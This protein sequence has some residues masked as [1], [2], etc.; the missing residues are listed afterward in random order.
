MR[1]DRKSGVVRETTVVD[2]FGN[3]TTIAFDELRENTGPA[4]DL[5][6]LH[7]ARGRSRDH[8]A[9]R[10]LSCVGPGAVP[11]ALCPRTAI[12]VTRGARRANALHSSA[13]GDV[14][15]TA[16]SESRRSDR[17]RRIPS[18]RL[19]ASC[20]ATCADRRASARAVIARGS[21]T[22]LRASRRLRVNRARRCA[23]THW[24]AA[25]ERLAECLGHV[26]SLDTGRCSD[27]FELGPKRPKILGILALQRDGGCGRAGVDRHAA[28]PL[29]GPE[30][31]LDGVRPLFSRVASRLRRSTA[32]ARSS[33][34]RLRVGADES[35][36][37]TSRVSRVAA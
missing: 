35:A 7:A 6:A 8:P 9:E 32:P 19:D 16:P 12:R 5:F 25:S 34:A 24:G 4:A 27:M 2:L 28:D 3:R 17:S 26:S 18:G 36:A 10:A 21:S 29:G 15:P 20:A 11:A 22:A 14:S 31:D 33:V 37:G 30:R 1:V 23:S 13:A